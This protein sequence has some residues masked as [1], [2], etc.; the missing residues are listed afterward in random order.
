MKYVPPHVRYY[1]S[2]VVVENIVLPY[3]TVVKVTTEK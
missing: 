3:P 1:N 2:E